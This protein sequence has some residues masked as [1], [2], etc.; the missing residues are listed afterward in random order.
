MVGSSSRSVTGTE[1]HS[2]DVPISI[3]GGWLVSSSQSI[4]PTLDADI[5]NF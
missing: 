4:S 3:T 5:F 2:A 1:I